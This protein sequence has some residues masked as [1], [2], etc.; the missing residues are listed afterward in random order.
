MD[1][2]YGTGG[3]AS[4]GRDTGQDGFGS[5]T[6]WIYRT[7]VKPL[8]LLLALNLDLPRAHLRVASSAWI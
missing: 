4:I 8:R 3:E 2:V 1:Y 5:S 6:G 7:Q